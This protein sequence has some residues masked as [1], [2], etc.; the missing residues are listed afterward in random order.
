MKSNPGPQTDALEGHAIAGPCLTRSP[1]SQHMLHLLQLVNTI[2]TYPPR[3]LHQKKLRPHPISIGSRPNQIF[4]TSCLAYKYWP[5]I[6]K[7]TSSHNSYFTKC[8]SRNRANLRPLTATG[9]KEQNDACV[10]AAAMR[11]TFVKAP[12]IWKRKRTG[13]LEDPNTISHSV[14]TPKNRAIKEVQK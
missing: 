11:T 7:H 8:K 10:M 12:R 2:L 1:L 9:S 6:V 4:T 14:I 5:E 13:N 3:H